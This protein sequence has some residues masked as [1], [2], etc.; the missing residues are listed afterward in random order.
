MINL[1]VFFLFFKILDDPQSFDSTVSLFTGL[2]PSHNIYF[3]LS[4]YMN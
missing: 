3:V 4:I 1:E 2:E